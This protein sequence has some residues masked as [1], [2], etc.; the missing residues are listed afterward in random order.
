MPYEGLSLEGK[1][2]LVTGSARGIGEALAVG[3]AQAGADVAVS[4]MPARLE[5]ATA[6]RQ[7][8]CAIGRHS[9]AYALDVLDLANIGEAMSRVAG[10]FGQ[11]DILV[12]NAGIRVRKP[13]PGTLQKKTGTAWLT[14]TSR[15]SSSAPRPP[16]G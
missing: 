1:T 11:L 6:V 16:P 14:P 7:R 10:D 9:E 3:L 8:I 5:Q 2:A 4:D 13:A 12:N 15:A